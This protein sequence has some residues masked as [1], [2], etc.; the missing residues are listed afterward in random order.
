MEW[1]EILSVRHPGHSFYW[2]TPTGETRW[3]RPRVEVAAPPPEPARPPPAGGGIPIHPQFSG[4]RAPPPR[5]APPPKRPAPQTPAGA[6]LAGGAAGVQSLMHC[7]RIK[8][9]KPDRGHGFIE[10]PA[11]FQQFGRDVHFGDKV[12]VAAGADPQSGEML[13][14][15]LVA[16]SASSGSTGQTVS[17]EE[18]VFVP[19]DGEWRRGTV[20]NWNMAKGAGFIDCPDIRNA[21]GRDVHLGDRVLNGA[22]IT[23]TADLNGAPLLFIAGQSQRGTPQAAAVAGFGLGPLGAQPGD[24]APMTGHLPRIAPG[25]AAAPRGAGHSAPPPL[26][27]PA[28]PGGGGGGQQWHTGTIKNWNV[29]RGFGFIECPEVRNQYGRDCHL[30]DK[31]LAA[32]GIEG[33][34]GVAVEFLCGQSARGTPQAMECRRA[35]AAPEQVGPE[36]VGEELVPNSVMGSS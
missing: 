33:Y 36:E 26:V 2:H 20:K 14:G 19:C 15:Q 4:K 27:P 11:T 12:L 29:E 31:V 28:A 10:S 32:V 25:P 6:M 7:G 30:G 21:H 16:F 1:V 5:D 3:E 23:A 9:F 34:D 8:W 17:A 13:R 35:P 18:I 22:G 24:P